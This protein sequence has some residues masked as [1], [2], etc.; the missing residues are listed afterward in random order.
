[1]FKARRESPPQTTEIDLARAAGRDAREKVLLTSIAELS[2]AVQQ[3]QVS[4][5][6]FINFAGLIS[7]GALTIGL[8]QSKHLVLIAA[9]YGLTIVMVYLVQLYTDIERLTTL[10]EVSEKHLNAMLP[11]PALPGRNK[12]AVHYRGRLSVRMLGGLNTAV[13]IVFAGLGLAQTSGTPHPHFGPVDLHILNVVG[14]AICATILLTAG[15]EMLHAGANAEREAEAA[16]R[17]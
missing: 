7:I 9:P 17:T 10:R 14:L 12:V 15:I 11:T 6:S 5:V 13:I 4:T 8:V 1:V 3:L 16:L 2:R